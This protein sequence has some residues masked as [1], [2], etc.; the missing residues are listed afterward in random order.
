[1]KSI[2]L[3]VA[4]VSIMLVIGGCA[5]GILA[6][7]S[8]G[9][10]DLSG[11]TKSD[12]S[13]DKVTFDMYV[14]SQCPFGVQVED[15]MIPVAK[16]FGDALEFNI[17]FI[18]DDLGGGNFKALHGQPE[19]DGNIVQL[20]AEKY[21]PDQYL[22][23]IACMNED[24]S[25]I[26][27]NWKSCSDKLGLDTASIGT[28]FD[29][30]EGKD[31][32]SESIKRTNAAG[33]RASPTMF[34]NGQPYEGGRDQLDFHRAICAAMDGEHEACTDIPA[35]AADAECVA[36][37]DKVGTCQNPG[38]KEA[39]CVYTDPVPVKLT[40]LTSEDCPNCDTAGIVA[41]LEMLFK[42]LTTETVDVSSAEGKALVEKTSASVVPV[43]V[44]DE[45]LTETA[46]YK[47][48]AQLSSAF[49]KV[50]GGYRLLDMV[51]GASYF[52]DE[53]ARE[54]HY[55][56]IGVTKGDNRPQI[57]FFVMSYCP[58]GN[59]AEEAVK[60]AFDVLKGKADFNPQWVIYSN[61]QGGGE[62]YC[63]PG[64]DDLCS[65]HGQVELNQNIREQCVKDLY[66]EEKFFEFA[67][68]M[69]SKCDYNNAD[70]CWTGVASG[71]AIDT[72]KVQSC[73]DENAESIADK[74][75]KMGNKL[76]VQGSPTVFIDG[77]E[78][79]GPRTAEGYLSALCSAFDEKPAECENIAEIEFATP[80]AQAPAIGAGCG[81]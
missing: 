47:A 55:K 46:S 60:G 15:A 26:P 68:A 65:M 44:F 72:A 10:T 70:T 39:K 31:L 76:G 49:E 28:C 12:F 18:A 19:V 30:S 34:L 61:Y 63:L 81:I 21:N 79:N 57:D 66:S 50:D 58:Y 16:K 4:L 3:T 45:A 41:Q 33:A 75:L 37:P 51:T 48:S 6:P 5:G 78:Y 29:G 1:M 20:C 40:I 35:C 13:G 11:P 56:D 14:M 74:S 32:H 52:I 36:Q 25:K 64:R 38:Q 24:A 67:L 22:D 62:K 43:Y 17:D 77:D 2:L 69:N 27:D 23:L 59:Q 7:V 80:A 53:K 8:T 42:G 54:Q 9:K 71:M 73:F